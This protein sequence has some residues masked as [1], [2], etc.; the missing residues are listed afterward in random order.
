M[1]CCSIHRLN[2]LNRQPSIFLNNHFVNRNCLWHNDVIDLTRNVGSLTWNR[3][4]VLE[5]FLL[6]LLQLPTIQ[7]ERKG[8]FL[9]AGKL[10]SS[11]SYPVFCL[12]RM[13]SHAMILGPLCRLESFWFSATSGT[14]ML[15]ISF[16]SLLYFTLFSHLR[17]FWLKVLTLIST[18][19][20][21]HVA[22]HGRPRLDSLPFGVPKYQHDRL[23]RILSAAALIVCLVPNSSHHA[24]ALYNLHWLPVPNR[25]QFEILL[26]AHR[27]LCPSKEAYKFQGGWFLQ[28]LKF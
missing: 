3:Y 24:A 10:L 8:R 20:F 25:I 21:D 5:T 28:F 7:T 18:K 2:C 11:T 17:S 19:R 13:G 16:L 4:P 27:A 15:V 12:L 23:Q 1:L 22:S 9:A 6:S 26:P 14:V